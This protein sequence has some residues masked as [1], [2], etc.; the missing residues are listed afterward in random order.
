MSRLSDP[1]PLAYDVLNGF[2]EVLA[3]PIWKPEGIP[4]WM[5]VPCYKIDDERVILHSAERLLL[6]RQATGEFD[7]STPDMFWRG[8]GLVTHAKT[9]SFVELPEGAYA[10]GRRISKVGTAQGVIVPAIFTVSPKIMNDTH[11][12]AYRFPTRYSHE[13]ITADSDKLSTLTGWLNWIIEKSAASLET[14]K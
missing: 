10:I 8:S 6:S 3:K 7:P 14:A 1:S 13:D 11:D 5:G 4:D 9:S 12:T 2:E